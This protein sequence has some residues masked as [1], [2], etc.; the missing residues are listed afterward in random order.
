MAEILQRLKSTMAAHM[1][2]R[3][4]GFVLK[5][6]RTAILNECV[7]YIRTDRY[8]K[9]DVQRLMRTLVSEVFNVPTDYPLVDFMLSCPRKR[10]IEL[11]RNTQRTEIEIVFV[12]DDCFSTPG[13]VADTCTA[14]CR[15]S[16]KNG[17]NKSI[18]S[19]SVKVQRRQQIIGYYNFEDD[20]QEFFN[21]Y[22]R[23]HLPRN[24]DAIVQDFTRKS[25]NTKKTSK[26]LVGQLVSLA[27]ASLCSK[28]KKKKNVELKVRCRLGTTERLTCDLTI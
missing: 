20:K 16:R 22:L 18:E 26:Q 6:R 8:K 1:G 12:F 21:A 17:T 3:V 19:M 13:D 23:G 2:R 5:D 7:D 9:P 11:T 24:L 14:T 15:V 25:D 28:K 27:A 4:L 10:T